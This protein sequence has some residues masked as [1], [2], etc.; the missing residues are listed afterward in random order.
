MALNFNV[1]SPFTS[2]IQSFLTRF[3]QTHNSS[4]L[5]DERNIPPTLLGTT[6]LSS[7]ILHPPNNRNHLSKNH[8]TLSSWYLSTLQSSSLL[9][10]ILWWSGCCKVECLCLL[11]YT[12]FARFFH[13]IRVWAKVRRSLAAIY[14]EI[15][16]TFSRLTHNPQYSTAHIIHHLA[17]A[18]PT[19]A[20]NIMCL[21]PPTRKFRPK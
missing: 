4:F 10:F 5:N 16:R 15:L 13:S 12:P 21:P 9:G 1:Y 17:A 6:R 20:N 2:A 8:I 3:I 7:H 11:G 18:K 19:D 14:I